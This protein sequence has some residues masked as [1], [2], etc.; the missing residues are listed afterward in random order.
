VRALH[1]LGYAFMLAGRA[2]EAEPLL[3]Q[4][5]DLRAKSRPAGDYRVA[6]SQVALED[7]LERL[8]RTAE[9]R[10]LYQSAVDSCG[11]MP[12]PV[13]LRWVWPSNC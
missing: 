10:P 2:C 6:Q 8:G 7:C 1:A 5:L 11:G 13:W 3:R 4:A 9:T 12:V